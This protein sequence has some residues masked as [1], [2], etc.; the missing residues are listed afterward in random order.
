MD[1]SITFDW[2]LC[3]KK[4]NNNPELAKELLDLFMAE[5]PTFT[6][7]IQEAQNK[8]DVKGL[9][10]TVHKLH[11]ACCYIG[12]PRLKQLVSKTENAL[13][14]KK[15]KISLQDISEILEEIRKI[16]NISQPEK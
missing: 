12:V 15:A 14:Q 11:G 9:L 3:L 13:K 7:Q 2:G 10:D 16:K 5:L 6:Q 8:N 4:C 1:D